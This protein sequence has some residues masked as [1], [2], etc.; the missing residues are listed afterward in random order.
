MG[1]IW[2]DECDSFSSRRF[3]I[4]TS[5]DQ[6]KNG[7]A[8]HNFGKEDDLITVGYYNTV[9]GLCSSTFQSSSI[10]A[11][12]AFCFDLQTVSVEVADG[13]TIHYFDEED[14]Y[15]SFQW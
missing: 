4:Q 7:S 15:D 5:F 2:P 13:S 14:D 6:A 10:Q 3:E 1:R 12:D 8:T 9:L 11:E